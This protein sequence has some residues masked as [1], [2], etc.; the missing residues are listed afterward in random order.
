[1]FSIANCVPQRG[2]TAA[3][4]QAPF[5]ISPPCIFDGRRAALGYTT[6]SLTSLLMGA[7]TLSFIV[8]RTSSCRTCEEHPLKKTR[9]KSESAFSRSK[10]PCGG[11]GV[12]CDA[13]GL[14]EDIPESDVDL[15]LDPLGHIRC[16]PY[17][18]SRTPLART[19]RLRGL[20]AGR[21]ASI[22][23]NISG[24]SK[25]EPPHMLPERTSRPGKPSPQESH[26]R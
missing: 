7:N 9:D 23:L 20:Y 19:L 1:M 12:H 6:R 17:S 18:S 13:I 24:W 26:D 15:R 2:E 21:S 4:P 3:P 11:A 5:Q 22:A 25:D 14:R 10:P 8:S 16:V